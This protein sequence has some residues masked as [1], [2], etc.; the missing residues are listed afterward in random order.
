MPV[1]TEPYASC[2]VVRF[3]CIG[4]ASSLEVAR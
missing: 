1:I 3:K 2:V 4:A